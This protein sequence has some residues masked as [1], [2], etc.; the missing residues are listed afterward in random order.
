MDRRGFLIAAGLAGMAGLWDRSAVAAGDQP[1][2]ASEAFSWELLQQRV[3]KL[4]ETRY[5]K[6]QYET[7]S[8]LTELNYDD[9]R[10]IQFRPEKSFWRDEPSV[11]Q[12][13][14]FHSGYI[15]PDPVDIFI[16]ENGQAS[17]IAFSRDLFRYDDHAKALRDTDEGGFSGLRLHSAKTE[18]DTAD[19]FTVFQGASYFRSRARGQTYGISARGL[20]IN[21]VQPGGEEFP[22]FHAYWVEK[23]KEG[24]D[25]ITVYALM[26]SRS[27][28]GAYRFVIRRGEVNTVMEIDCHLSPRRSL[29]YVGVAAFSSMFFFG[30]SDHTRWDDFRPRVHDSDGLSILDS[31]GDWIW[32]PLITGRRML[33]SVFSG[34]T[35]AG[36][37]L[38]QRERDAKD[39]QDLEAFYEKR[40]GTWVEP[41]GDWGE[42][43]VDLIELPT[44]SE[45]MDNVVAFWRPKTPMQAGQSHH[46]NYRLTWCWEAPVERNIGEIV[47]VRGGKGLV[48][49]ARFLLIDIAGGEITAEA[50]E[51]L[52]DIQ[53]SASKGTI[54]AYSVAPNRFVNGKRIG[55]EYYPVDEEDA[56]LSFQIR[57]RDG[58]ALSEKWIYRWSP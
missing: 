50:D 10:N 15:Y 52:W 25:S 18:T 36:F 2:A 48:H 13:Q 8:A 39:Y 44:N 21:T 29:E 46:Y 27:V 47:R 53:A 1:A 28:A 35:P 22:S 24:E 7:K 55:I 51:K 5:D 38:M 9:Y 16:V 37:G 42:G 32:R 14:L 30:P 58:K 57:S 49:G 19:E 23:P 17:P 40:P 6:R 43:S 34:G 20:A 31:A 45:Y 4:A 54:K 3:R 41:Q 12:M 26:D 33:Y 11:F 56:D